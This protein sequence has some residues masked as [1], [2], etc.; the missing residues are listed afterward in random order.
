MYKVVSFTLRQHYCNDLGILI[1]CWDIS[2]VFQHDDHSALAQVA[3]MKSLGEHLWVCNG[4]GSRFY[5]RCNTRGY[6]VVRAALKIN[7]Y[8]Y[9]ICLS[10][11]SLKVGS[12]LTPSC[13]F[14]PTCAHAW[15]ALMH[16]LCPSVTRKYDKN[17]LHKNSY[18]WNH[19]T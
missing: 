17:S 18:L 4:I 6:E 11:L 10:Y 8:Q 15:W 1:T 2:S 19:L 5:S 3:S 12:L 7:S 9:V 14:E 13:I 16:N